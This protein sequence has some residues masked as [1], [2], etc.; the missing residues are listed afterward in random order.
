MIVADFVKWDDRTDT[1]YELAFGVP[2]AMAP[3]SGR[4]AD[5]VANITAR[6]GA[7][8]SFGHVVCQWAPEWRGAT[9]ATSSGCQTSS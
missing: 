9:T 1:R 4:H 2:V 8:S 5:I 3:P 7:D 6:L